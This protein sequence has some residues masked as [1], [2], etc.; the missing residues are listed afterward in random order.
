[1]H[2]WFWV[3]RVRRVWYKSSVLTREWEKYGPHIS[4]FYSLRIAK[5]P[6]YKEQK[7]HQGPKEQG[8]QMWYIYSRGTFDH[9]CPMQPFIPQLFC[10]VFF[11]YVG[12]KCDLIFHG[13]DAA[14][15]P[16]QN[17]TFR[18]FILMAGPQ[19]TRESSYIYLYI[20][21]YIWFLKNVWDAMVGWPL[22]KPPL[23]IFIRILNHEEK[24]TIILWFPNGTATFFTVF[25]NLLLPAGTCITMFMF[26]QRCR[27]L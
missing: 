10:V 3:R 1:M 23:W 20:Y 26:L 13:S 27:G 4:W 8:F 15:Q 19:K 11:F 6:D 25:P 14:K 9:N 24:K 22:A 5:D 16:T 12:K 21:I 7:L 2:V 17:N 18:F